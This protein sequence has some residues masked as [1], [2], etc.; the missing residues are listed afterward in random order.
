DVDQLTAAQ[1][2]IPTCRL[3][4]AVGIGERVLR[5]HEQPKTIANRAE[6]HLRVAQARQIEVPSEIVNELPDLD[7]VATPQGDAV[8]LHPEPRWC[9]AGNQQFVTPELFAGARGERVLTGQAHGL[10]VDLRLR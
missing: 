8:Q 9:E 10:P 4:E 2:P 7:M 1:A 3:V 6:Q 5:P